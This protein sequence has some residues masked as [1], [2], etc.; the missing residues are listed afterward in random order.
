AMLTI[1]PGCANKGIFELPPPNS[2]DSIHD[3][4]I[5][6]KAPSDEAFAALQ[7]HAGRFIE[8]GNFAKAKA[9]FSE[10]SPLFPKHQA[11]I[12]RIIELFDEYPAVLPENIGQFVNS[13]GS[14]IFP[15]FSA[16]GDTLYFTG[17]NR[18]DNNIGD[19]EDIFAAVHIDN[20]FETA[21]PLTGTLSSTQFNDAINSIS[22][23]G[24]FTL[25][26]TNREDPMGNNAFIM[27]GSNTIT[28]FPHPVNSRYFDSDAIMTPDGTTIIFVSD[29]PGGIGDYHANGMPFRDGFL[30]NTD[31]YIAHKTDGE[32]KK[33]VNLGE[34]INTPY[35]ERTP[36][37]IDGRILVFS[38]QG[39]SSIGGM[40]IFVSFRKG[41]G[42]TNWTQPRNIGL[43][44]NSPRDDWGFVISPDRK[45]AYFSS[46]RKGG[47]GNRDGGSG[48]RDG[49]FGSFDIYR[50]PIEAIEEKLQPPPEPEP[51]VEE[52][53]AL[54]P[55]PAREPLVTHHETPD[56]P[57]ESIPEPII[58][59]Q[60]T[61]TFTVRFEVNGVS[62]R[63]EFYSKLD[64]VAVIMRQNPP[65]KLR[66]DGFT[67][68]LGPADYNLRL[69]RRRAQA[70]ADFI[71]DR[72][73]SRGRLLIEGHGIRTPIADNT[74]DRGRA[75]NRR[76]ECRLFE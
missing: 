28:E 5:R 8:D 52:K 32:W 56:A 55:E 34:V 47:S 76:V 10:Y 35:A 44:I 19:T 54:E 73:I 30:G 17:R 59:F 39:H 27:R 68:N 36:Y 23:D 43:S 51:I 4:F 62:I 50:I 60:L 58:Q 49:G 25:L 6:D 29:R 46:D 70:V 31:I 22:P 63:R 16:D 74:T 38:S 67:D 71:A 26:F 69:S 24:K 66:I 41:D 33:P 45:F 7:N 14:E 9:I 2:P 42:W 57:T 13:P 1:L 11:N 72:G 40:D 18:A 12:D 75:L 21:K 53:P 20:A 37:L 64:S 61:D 65:L 15:V 48:N 3:N